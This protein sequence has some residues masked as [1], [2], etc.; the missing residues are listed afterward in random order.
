MEKRELA[1]CPILKAV[2]EEPPMVP[3]TPVQAPP[4]AEERRVTFNIG[5]SDD[6]DTKEMETNANN[7]ESPSLVA[8]PCRQDYQPEMLVFIDSYKPE[9]ESKF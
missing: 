1:T 7:G 4:P 5:D 8:T 9:M 3:D 6:A 2:P